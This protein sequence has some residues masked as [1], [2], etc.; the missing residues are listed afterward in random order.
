VKDYFTQTRD[1]LRDL[2]GFLANVKVSQNGKRTMSPLT[3]NLTRF[4]C[5]HR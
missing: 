4:L 5:I 1:Q 2:Y 3:R